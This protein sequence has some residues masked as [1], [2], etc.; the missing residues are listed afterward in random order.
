MN[1]SPKHAEFV[2]A[3]ASC[4]NATEAA[5]LA[6]Y[7]PRCASS[8]G[9]RLLK[10]A[11]IQCAIAAIRER[12]TTEAVMDLTEACERLSRIARA[13]DDD[14]AIRA[15]GALSKLRGWDSPHKIA[16]TDPSGQHEY[17]PRLDIGEAVTEYMGAISAALA[18]SAPMQAP[19]PAPAPV[20]LADRPKLKARCV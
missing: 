4:L 10:D 19:A 13:A 20:P 11:K 16:L 6:G 7:S 12:A 15:I 1:L 14:L 8:Q 17:A 9:A 5:R 2:R 18:G 3:Y